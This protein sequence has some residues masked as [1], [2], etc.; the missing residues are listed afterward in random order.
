MYPVIALKDEM[1]TPLN[2]LSPQHEVETT[3]LLLMFDSN[4]PAIPSFNISPDQIHCL[5]KPNLPI[6]KTLLIRESNKL[7]HYLATTSLD[8]SQDI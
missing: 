5:K 2:L 8:Y 6:N 7:C 3:P 1:R 4:E